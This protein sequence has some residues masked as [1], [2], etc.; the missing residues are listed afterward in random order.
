MTEQV[1]RPD[2]SG[3]LLQLKSGSAWVPILGVQSV[4]VSGGDRETSTF[5]TLDGGVESTFGAAGVKDIALTLNPSFMNAQWR[6]LVQNAYYSNDVVTVRYRTLANI[7]DIAKGASGHG[8]SITKI[9]EGLGNEGTLTFEGSDGASKTATDEIQAAGELGLVISGTDSAVDGE[10]T[11]EEPAKGKFLIARYDG[12]KMLAS[13]WNGQEV[14]AI[15]TKDGWVLIRYGIAVEYTCR[16]TSAANPDFATGSAIG[17]TV[18]LR[19]IASGMKIYPITK[20]A[21]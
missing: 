4:S 8:F 19:Q 2:G 9:D 11:E 6:K 20:A 7:S 5:E 10:R 21:K 18:N 1:Y 14:S 12:S 16:V 3:G 13:E 17:E 15:T